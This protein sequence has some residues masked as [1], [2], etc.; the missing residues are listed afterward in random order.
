MMEK[1]EMA[2]IAA[3]IAVILATV[4]IYMV[5]TIPPA[6]IMPIQG[7]LGSDQI[8]S[9]VL[10]REPL[11]ATGKAFS[12]IYLYGQK[13][14]DSYKGMVVNLQ[15]S[16]YWIKANSTA[17]GIQRL[18]IVVDPATVNGVADASIMIQG[19]V[20]NSTWSFTKGAYAYVSG[21]PGEIT[22]TRPASGAVTQLAGW[23]YNTSVFYFNPAY[24]MTALAL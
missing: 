13:V 19:L 24:N 20:Y 9:I 6:Q 17:V 4:A 18:G 12:G 1:S 14:N 16:G 8:G 11:P 15:P 10:M 7:A 3:V 5:A 23:A 21:T 2:V 22:V